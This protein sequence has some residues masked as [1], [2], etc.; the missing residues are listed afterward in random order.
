MRTEIPIPTERLEEVW[1]MVSSDMPHFI[2][3][4]EPLAPPAA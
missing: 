4:I 1:R 3:Q 2:S